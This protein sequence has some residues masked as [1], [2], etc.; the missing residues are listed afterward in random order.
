MAKIDK[1][2]EKIE[3]MGLTGAAKFV[4]IVT[5]L[6]VGM[7]VYW[8]VIGVVYHGPHKA[9]YSEDI[10][11]YYTGLEISNDYNGIRNSLFTLRDAIEGNVSLD[12]GY[13]WIWVRENHKAKYA[14]KEIDAALGAL[15]ERAIVILND[16]KLV[17]HTNE[18]SNNTGKLSAENISR[19]IGDVINININQDVYNKIQ[20]LYADVK[21]MAVSHMDEGLMFDIWQKENHYTVFMLT[22][23]FFIVVAILL[24]IILFASL[25]IGFMGVSNN[26]GY[27]K[28]RP[29]VCESEFVC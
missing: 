19:T 8:V 25:I 29:P 20:G 12:S 14:I 23:P 22:E 15:Y 26:N 13:D 5:L 2:T 21:E 7:I 24:S 4:F 27:R 11:Q 17:E 9:E 16:E 1:K 18:T 6:F 10:G 3:K 28:K